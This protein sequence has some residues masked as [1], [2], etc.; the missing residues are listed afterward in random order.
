LIKF[1]TLTFIGVLLE[2]IV[3]IFAYTSSS[4]QIAFFQTA[5]RI[6]GRISLA[7]FTLL[8]LYTA[9]KQQNKATDLALFGSFAIVHVIHWCLLATFIYLSGTELIPIRLAGGVVAYLL[10]VLYPILLWRNLGSDGLRQ[11]IRTA[12]L[13]FVWFVMFMTYLSRVKQEQKWVGGDAVDYKILF[14]FVIILLIIRLLKVFR[15]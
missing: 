8:F 6:S 9:W 7:Y 1:S 15:K 12:H 14:Y 13:Y 3:L 2:I 11:K 5:A 4:D 10:T